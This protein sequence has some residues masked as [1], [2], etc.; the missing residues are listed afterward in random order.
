MLLTTAQQVLMFMGM[1]LLAILVE[2]LA[3]AL[4]LPF[5]AA[6]VLV[7]FLGS[8]WLVMQGIDTGLRWDNFQDLI[9]YVFIP[10]VVFE[11]AFSIDPRRLLRDL[12]PILALAMPVMLAATFIT[13]A[14]VYVGIG[15]P[16]GFPWIAALITGTILSST[17][18]AAVIALM[19]AYPAHERLA[20]LLDG[21][22]LLND[23]LAIVLYAMLIPIALLPAG[24]VDWGAA[25]AWLL[26]AFFG[27]AAVGVAIGAVAILLLHWFREVVLQ[28]L[29]TLISAYVCFVVTDKFLQWSGVMAVLSC[30]LLLG[31]YHRRASDP[32]TRRFVVHLWEFTGY[33]AGS[34]I[35]LLGGVTVT[36][37]MF[38]EQW[39][40]MLIGIA[41]ATAARFLS[42][43]AGLGAVRAL[44]KARPLRVGEQAV[45]A[46]GGVRGT[47]TL[48]LALS[49]PLELDYWF[50]VQ[51]IAYGV[52]LFTLFVQSPTFL[53]VLRRLA[54]G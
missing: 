17:D 44:P 15:A 23:A 1:L 38:R 26:L 10:A 52:V 9:L 4:R 42:V 16:E 19:K 7:G 37:L 8:N 46:W 39:L 20:L 3:R 24:K 28:G 36:L 11:S 2:P 6:L 34:M 27:G 25:T 48:A 33:V 35:F 18:P 30:A 31:E 29:I 14:V 12:A 41:A 21:E 51:S 49:L 43:F 53:P 5:A 22:S 50:T 32:D 13:A 47:V 54:A 40:A 45:I